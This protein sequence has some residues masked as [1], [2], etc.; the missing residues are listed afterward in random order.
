MQYVDQM[1]A[2]LKHAGYDITFLNGSSITV[3]FFTTQLN[4]Y[5]VLIWRTDSFALGNTTYWY[6][7]NQNNQ[8]N[9]EGAIGIGSVAVTNGMV[10]VSEEFFS[11]TYASNALAHIK[12]AI[13]ISSMSITIAQS[14]IEAGVTTTIDFYQTLD[15]PPSLFD[16]VTQS[17]VGYLT[18]GSAVRDA[19]YKTIYNYEYA[20]SLDD[21][22][23]PPI[24]FLG[25]GNLQIT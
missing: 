25:N 8:T 7:G 24:S 4:K 10:A 14:L 23:L 6:L 19:I 18:T 11:N 12:L 16:W 9:Y 15:A 5:D 3:S 20:G 1:T 22:Y 13:L 2:E 17:L 21:T